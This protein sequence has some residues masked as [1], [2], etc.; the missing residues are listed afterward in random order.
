MVSGSKASGSPHEALRGLPGCIRTT[1]IGGSGEAPESARGVSGDLR[2]VSG[3]LKDVSKGVSER[4]TRRFQGRFRGFSEA[5]SRKVK[6][7]VAYITRFDV[8]HSTFCP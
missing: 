3:D 5:F 4:R 6:E 2:S 7:Y 8:W 1:S